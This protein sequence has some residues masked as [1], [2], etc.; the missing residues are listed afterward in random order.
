MQRRIR[1]VPVRFR[2]YSRELGVDILSVVGY[3]A[4]CSCGWRS[5][6][7]KSVAAARE[8]ARDHGCEGGCGNG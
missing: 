5:P 3:R 7:R 1:V 8:L 2:A 4:V 6:L